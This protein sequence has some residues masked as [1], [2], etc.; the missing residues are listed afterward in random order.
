MLPLEKLLCYQRVGKRVLS[1]DGSSVIDT[2]RKPRR[3]AHDLGYVTEENLIEAITNKVVCDVSSGYGTLY[4]YLA[5]RGIQTNIVP[6]NPRVQLEN[7]KDGNSLLMDFDF[8]DYPVEEVRRVHRLHNESVVAAFAHK[9]PFA[10][11]SFDLVFDNAAV[12]F[13]SQEEDECVYED[14]LLEMLRILRPGGEIRIGDW[15]H[16]GGGS[17]GEETFPSSQEN[18]LKRLN[19]RYEYIQEPRGKKREIIGVI[20]YK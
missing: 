20:I 6:V 12:S 16:Y 14:S 2:N 4:K 3:Y 18:I 11:N 7:Y 19:I 13:Y 9:L 15:I 5:L 8:P 1:S 10:N 17:S